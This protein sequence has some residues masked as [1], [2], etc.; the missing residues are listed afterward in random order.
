MGTSGGSAATNLDLI[1]GGPNPASCTQAPPERNNQPPV[2]PV[3][4][5]KLLRHRQPVRD[6]L[7]V[8][9]PGQGQQ[10]RHDRAG[11]ADTKFGVAE[12]M[13]GGINLT[14]LG[15]GDTCFS[16][17][18]A[19]TRVV[20]LG[21]L[22]AVRLR[23]RRVRSVLVGLTTTPQAAERRDR[24]HGPSTAARRPVDRRK[25][26]RDGSRSCRTHDL[27]NDG[28]VRRNRQVLPLRARFR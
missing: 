16:S 19:E 4:A 13:E 2:P 14:A 27:R 7:A 20:A 1:G 11:G 28:P 17:F 5:T 23:A 6:Q 12:F 26:P 15:F 9:L 8:A 21:D 18:M 3:A 22:D 25:R 10:R 24:Q